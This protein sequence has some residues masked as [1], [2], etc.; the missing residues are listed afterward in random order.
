MKKVLKVSL[1]G[2]YQIKIDDQPLNSLVSSKALGILFYLMLNKRPFPRQTIASLFWGEMR[3]EDARRNLRGV[4]MKLRQNLA[5]YLLIENQTVGFN[6]DSLYELDIEQFDSFRASGI[7]EQLAQAISMHRGDFLAEFHLRDAPEF[8]YW[9]ERERRKR[10]QLFLKT[11][12]DLIGRYELTGKYEAGIEIAQQLIDIEPTR[13]A[14]HR[15]LIRLFALDGQLDTAVDH[16]EGLVDIL[17]NE[18]QVDPADETVL[19]LHEI[20]YG[21]ETPS[22]FANPRPEVKLISEAPTQAEKAVPPP[23]FIAGP[24]ITYPA[25]FFGREAIVKRI[26]RLFQK[27]PFQ[28]AAIIGPRRSGKTSL[29]HYLKSIHSVPSDQRRPDQTANW[30]DHPN[31]YRWVFVDFQDARFGE[32]NRLLSYLLTHMGLSLPSTPCDLDTFLDI[33]ADELTS[34]T[35]IIFDEIGVALSRYG[36]TLDDAFWESLR[37]LATNQLDGQLGFVLSS[38]QP[39]NELATSQGFGSPF[40]NIF[41]YTAMLRA[42]NEDEARQLISSSPLPFPAA[43]TEWILEKSQLMPMPLQILCRERLIAL[44]ENEEGDFWREDALLQ[45]QSFLPKD[46]E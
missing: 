29:L 32:L 41:G 10:H 38:H 30:L 11:A 14:S 19:L 20:R 25:R 40:F 15:H 43:D 39:P 23:S 42:F 13:E 24:P 21:K 37:S 12:D 35:I 9:Q 33:V 28:N 16:Y 46:T 22:A 3:D 1:L 36:A 34:P 26:F 8:E 31:Q 5:D 18:L 4:V 45:I 2:P 6:F 44:E 17:R 27:R 7:D